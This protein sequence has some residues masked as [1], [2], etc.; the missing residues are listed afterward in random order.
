MTAE[1]GPWLVIQ[2]S[3]ETVYK[4]KAKL[5]SSGYIYTPISV[6]M[7]NNNKLRERSQKF[8]RQRRENGRNWRTAREQSNDINTAHIHGF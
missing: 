1:R 8:K 7:S 4:Q 6:Y 5:D 2:V 3:T